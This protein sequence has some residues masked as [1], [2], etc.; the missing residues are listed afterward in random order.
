MSKTYEVKMGMVEG[1]DSHRS[2]LPVLPIVPEVPDIL[3][4]ELARRGWSVSGGV[5]SKRFGGATA[6]VELATGDVELKAKAEVELVGRGY[7]VEDN[8]ERGKRTARKDGES[9]RKAVQEQA[10]E[11][12]QRAMLDVS[13]DVR[14]E[15]LAALRD[16]NVRA[17]RVKAR[18]IG[19]VESES[20][21][22]NQR[23]ERE[24]KIK[25]RV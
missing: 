5:A 18:S 13:E 21:G 25:I 2:K 7:D 20:D 12:A 17:L 24:F 16:T 14:A 9:R 3:G 11:K 23:G 15:T 1:S 22:T 6:E 10:R 4:E 19:V 8:E